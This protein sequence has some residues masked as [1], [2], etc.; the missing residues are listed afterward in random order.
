ML[1]LENTV[2]RHYLKGFYRQFESSQE[3]THKLARLV[4]GKS[5][6]KND[7]G[8]GLRLLSRFK[9]GDLYCTSDTEIF[10]LLYITIVIARGI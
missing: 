6:R 8:R 7:E 5:R 9:V 1:N 2:F 3:V 10:E 4:S